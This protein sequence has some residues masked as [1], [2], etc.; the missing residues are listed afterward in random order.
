MTIRDLI[1]NTSASGSQDPPIG[2]IP[3]LQGKPFGGIA[4]SADGTH[5]VASMFQSEGGPGALYSSYDS[6]NTWN[7]IY[8]MTYLGNVAMSQDGAKISVIYSRW[9][10]NSISASY[11][12]GSTFTDFLSPLLVGMS[13]SAN[14]NITYMK[15]PSETVYYTSVIYKSINLGSFSPIIELGDFYNY[16]GG[17][18][19]SA[20]GNIIMWG[21]EYIYRSE[22]GGN[23]YYPIE[24]VDNSRTSLINNRA[25]EHYSHFS[26]QPT[27]SAVAIS[28][29][30]SK[31]VASK[32][33]GDTYTSNDS[34]VTWKFQPKLS[35]YQSN[36]SFQAAN[37]YYNFAQLWL[38][39]DGS[40]CYG[41]S[42][43]GISLYRFEVEY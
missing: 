36:D 29:D 35:L 39:A 38:C 9:P 6:G 20:N 1:I 27:W 19:T 42:T 12:A 43:G 21:G 24:T 28:M 2:V 40:V 14:G 18:S 15:G 16:F 4:C 22:D 32:S 10:T 34:G 13:C 25:E 8:M 30:G 33:A 11:N 3:A 37:T 5:V 17:I 31:I 23:T 7:I 26:L 41:A